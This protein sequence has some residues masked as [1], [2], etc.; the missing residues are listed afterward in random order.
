MYVC[1]QLV[2]RVQLFATR[3]VVHKAPLPMEYPRHAKILEWVAVLFSRGSS[4]S[5]DQARISCVSCI[6]RRILYHRATW[7]SNT[8]HLTFSFCVHSPIFYF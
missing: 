2:S 6:C 4:Q 7:E 8:E 5:K 3:T 1:A